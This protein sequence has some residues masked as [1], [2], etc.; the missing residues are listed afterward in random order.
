[1]AFGFSAT[2]LVLLGKTRS[3]HAINDATM[4][5][6]KNFGQHVVLDTVPSTPGHA[7]PL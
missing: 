7:L 5:Q 1:M 4:E 3:Q 6:G 2:S